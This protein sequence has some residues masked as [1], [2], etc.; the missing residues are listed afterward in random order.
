MKFTNNLGLR[1]QNMLKCWSRS[2]GGQP[3]AYVVNV[4]VIV[5]VIPVTSKELPEE[6]VYCDTHTC[7]VNMALRL[8]TYN[9][10]LIP[11][12]SAEACSLPAA[13]RINIISCLIIH[14]NIWQNFHWYLSS[15]QLCSHKKHTNH[16]AHAK[17]T[18]HYGWDD[19]KEAQACRQKISKQ[20]IASTTHLT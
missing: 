17:L 8:E 11:S 2:V 20:Q 5:A 3:R 19:K 9:W 13:G 4:W 15:R 1:Q 12:P 7:F 10:T 6:P 14:W 16:R 18:I